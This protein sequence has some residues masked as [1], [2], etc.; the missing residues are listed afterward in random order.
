M[1]KSLSISLVLVE[2]ALWSDGHSEWDIP[3]G[4]EVF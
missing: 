4:R 3:I 1:K 2:G